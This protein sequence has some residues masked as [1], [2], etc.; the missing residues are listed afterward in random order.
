MRTLSEIEEA[1][2]RLPADVQAQL[3]KDI[4]AL[5]PDAFPADGWKKILADATPR[6]GLSQLLDQVDSEY[7][8][9]PE[10][11]PVLNEDSLGDKK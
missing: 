5:C 7:R 2:A 1:I 10:R 3:I 4:P 9:A 8:H 6:R 11:F